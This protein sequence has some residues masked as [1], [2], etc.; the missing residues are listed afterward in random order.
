[1]ADYREYGLDA[2][3]VNKGS[4]R[5][6]G[7]VAYSIQW[8]QSLTEIVIDPVRCPDTAREFSEYEYLRDRNGDVISGYPDQNNHHIDAVRYAMA[9]V[10]RRGG[11]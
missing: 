7:S 3:G 10:W 8:L 5:G 2:H 9:E 1:M 11:R 6:K 4:V